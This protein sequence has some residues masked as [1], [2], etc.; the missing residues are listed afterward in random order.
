MQLRGN[1][2]GVRHKGI[3]QG[4]RTDASNFPVEIRQM[5]DGRANGDGGFRDSY[6][7]KAT[8]DS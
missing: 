3:T 8:R 6:E 7:L 2:I 4:N 1:A 5:F